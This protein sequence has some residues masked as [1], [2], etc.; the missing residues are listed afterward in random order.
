MITTYQ[1][2]V[3]IEPLSKNKHRCLQSCCA[4]TWLAG[5]AGVIASHVKLPNAARVAKTP[6]MWK[7]MLKA[8][9]T[10]ASTTAAVS[11]AYTCGRDNT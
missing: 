5:V 6:P 4:H 8:I 2:Q 11:V 9:P 7:V 1:V 10:A 3:T